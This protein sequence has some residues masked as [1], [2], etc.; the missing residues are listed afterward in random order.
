[1]RSAHALFTRLIQA[2][3][4]IGQ[5]VL[6][7][8]VA[9]ICYDAVVRYGFSAPTSW[10]LEVNTFLIVYIAAM[11][12]ADVQREDSHIRITFFTEKLGPGA[13]R[14]IR[15]LIGMVGVAFCL[16]MAWYGGAQ[17]LQ[18]A[19]HG[20]RESSSF[21]TPMAIPYAMMPIGFG[22]LALQ[23]L[24]DAFGVRQR[25][26]LNGNDAGAQV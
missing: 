20:E 4:L 24:L 7:F 5:L 16:G 11:T 23:F 12:A 26:Q 14:A 22:A 1:M 13:Q 10:S 2:L 25:F 21:G 19:V 9:T 6:F 3:S 8:M 17:T 15:V 18:A